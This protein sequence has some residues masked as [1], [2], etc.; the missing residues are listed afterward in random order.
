MTHD[1]E[2]VRKRP[3]VL[4]GVLVGVTSLH[5]TG[6]VDPMQSVAPPEVRSWLLI[7]AVVV[8]LCMTMLMLR[9][10]NAPSSAMLQRM[11]STIASLQSEVGAAQQELASA[12]DHVRK[13]TEELQELRSK[14]IAFERHHESIG[15]EYAREMHPRTSTITLYLTSP[16]ADGTF[17]DQLRSS[18][19]VAG[20]SM[21][22]LTL[23][24][25][26]QSSA[27]FALIMHRDALDLALRR[28][29]R[30]VE[31]YCETVNAYRSSV[32]GVETI[33]PGTVELSGGSWRVVKKATIKY[34]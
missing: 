4:I 33:E 22:V 17:D 15:T 12:L 30:F 8:V 2:R 27:S 29:E 34:V 20:E 28:R 32:V 9:C 26:R 5:L 6:C 31:P 16:E 24:P 14:A 18:H 7:A 10:M 23:D 21:Y 1:A 25:A 3:D 19:Y 11:E 13:L